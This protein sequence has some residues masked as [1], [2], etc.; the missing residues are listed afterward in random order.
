MPENLPE[1]I[2]PLT[3]YLE[4]SLNNPLFALGKERT[5]TTENQTVTRWERFAYLAYCNGGKFI[6]ESWGIINEIEGPYKIGLLQEEA[7]ELMRSHAIVEA[8]YWY[9]P[10]VWEVYVLK[11]NKYLEEKINTYKREYPNFLQN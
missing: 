1:K 7:I 5:K 4:T 9:E 3:V 6:V 2:S 11:I 8:C 10:N